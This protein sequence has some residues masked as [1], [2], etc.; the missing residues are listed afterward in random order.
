MTTTNILIAGV[1]GQGLVLSTRIISY[2]AFKEGFDI[3]SGDVIG[4][5]QR[6]GTV[7]GSVRFGKK[8]FSPIIP[9]G[10]ADVLLGLEEL[11][12][13]RWIHLMKNNAHIIVNKQNVFPNRVL[14]E[15]EE[16]PKDIVSELKN[17]G[18]QVDSVDARE[19][20][21]AAGNVK[22][23]NIVLLGKLSKL[24]PIKHETW[25]ETIKENV[26]AKTID[27]NITAFN[28]SRE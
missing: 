3:K 15:K 4:L 2:A 20:A 1:G 6:G 22:A 25:I 12:A 11:E 26:P 24:L 16:Y 13:L 18:F 27:I 8:V 19:I 28:K 9:N 14:L 21:R 10:E 23:E 5:S 17:K 7:W